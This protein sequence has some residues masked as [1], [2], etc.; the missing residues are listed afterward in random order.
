MIDLIEV[1]GKRYPFLFS[2]RAVWFLTSSGKIEIKKGE[3]DEETKVVAEY[4]DMLELFVIANKSAIGYDG[5]GDEIT[6]KELEKG[7]DENP[8]L[9]IELQNALSKS[10][11]LKMFQEMGEDK[12]KP[13]PG[14]KSGKSPTGN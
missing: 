4:D 9:F 2:M 12:K 7:I 13:S 10:G 8:R 1:R 14:K 3:T 6:A 11:V 5:K